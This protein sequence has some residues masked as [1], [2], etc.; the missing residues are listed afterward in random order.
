MCVYSSSLGLV[1]K[2][3]RNCQ[4]QTGHSGVYYLIDTVFLGSVLSQEHHMGLQGHA[5]QNHPL[6]ANLAAPRPQDSRCYFKATL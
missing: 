5:I 1:Q 6:G 4:E 2:V 3:F